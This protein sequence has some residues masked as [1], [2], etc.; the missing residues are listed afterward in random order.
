MPTPS[1]AITLRDTGTGL[2]NLER[3]RSDS[4]ELEPRY[5]YFIAELMMLRLFAIMEGAIADI[6]YKLVAGAT[7]LNGTEP[8]RLFSANSM[9][10]ARAAMLNYGRQNARQNLRWTKS[11]DI[12]DSTSTV[13]P[14]TE[15]F[16]RYARENG[17]LLDEMRKVRNYIAHNNADS[18]SGYRQVIRLTY[19]ANSKVSSGVFLVSIRRQSV[20]KIDEYIAN[21]RIIIADLVNGA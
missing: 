20:A 18:R 10:S 13:L 4:K 17:H 14:P 21:A 19:G 15:S 7:Y 6:A 12:R 8:I 3:F 2:N 11:K 9:A 16:I 5:Q 1:L